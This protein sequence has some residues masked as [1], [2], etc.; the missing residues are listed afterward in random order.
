MAEVEEPKFTT[1]AERIAALNQQKN[2]QAPPSTAGKRPPP[3]PP[4]ARTAT[5]PVLS[6]MAM[7]KS[8]SLPP[9]PT[10]TATENAPPLPRRNTEETEGR[11]SLAP[12]PTPSRG[13]PPP[14]PSRNAQ[15]QMAPPPE[16]PSRRPSGLNVSRRGSNSSDISAMSNLSLTDSQSSTRRL[17]P[18]LEDANL[19][20]LPPTR[21]E[22]EAAKKAEEEAAARSPSLPSRVSRIADPPAPSLPP[23]L[24]SRPTRSP[25]ADQ[26]EDTSPG[27]P[28]RRLPPPPSSYRPKSAIENGF[29]AGHRQTNGVPP[30]IPVSSRPSLSQIDAVVSRGSAAGRP[31]PAPPSR[32]LDCLKCRDFSGPDN[33]AARFPVANLPRQDVVGYLAHVLCDPFPSL[34]DKARAIF[35][36]CHHNI[37]YDVDSFFTNCIRHITPEEGIFEQKAVCSGYAGIYEG[38]A[39]RAGLECIVVTGH[40]KG[41]GYSP[42]AP[43]DRPPPRSADG[44]AWNAVRLDD[45]K[46]KLLD[47]CWGAGHLG[48]DN[49]YEKKFSPN[50]FVGTNEEFGLTHYP[51][52]DAHFFRED[53]RVP[54]W[55]EYYLGPCGYEGEPATL[56]GSGVDEG[57]NPYGFTPRAKRIKVYSG[58]I[59]QFR[60]SK[61]CEH[62]TVE[63]HGNKGGQMLF[64]IQIHGVDGRKDDLVALD[65]DGFWWSADIPARD[66][67]CPGQKLNMYGFTSIGNQDARGVTKAEWLRKKGRTGYALCGIAEWELV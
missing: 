67:G 34:T 8:P 9:R 18:T 66:L 32:G 30:P 56:Y 19:P 60:F 22:R 28:P 59:V 29:N 51:A 39:L 1:L 24:P 65:Y 49:K 15:K 10:R 64:A 31:P 26:T 53:G 44:H 46:W 5:E 13:G 58:Q 36:W 23:R 21:R 41:Y 35:T 2:F 52:D 54:T 11:R 57:L 38:L 6:N 27:L 3:P 14:L 25:T 62:W 12:P 4:P 40:G 17:P 48:K 47:A 33:V 42:V 55:D 50:E 63:K 45:G 43:G 20:P 7:Q 37:A 16:L 61:I